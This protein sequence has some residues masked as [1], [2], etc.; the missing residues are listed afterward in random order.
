MSDDEADPDTTRHRMARTLALI[1]G[2]AVSRPLPERAPLSP[3]PEIQ[4]A[5]V[6]TPKPVRSTASYLGL[7][8]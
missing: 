2:Q 8:D 4:P 5:P 3:A 6:P 1:R 7:E